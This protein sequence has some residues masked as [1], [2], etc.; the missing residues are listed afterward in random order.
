MVNLQEKEMQNTDSKFGLKPKD[1]RRAKE[2][3]EIQ[4]LH[5]Q[6]TFNSSP[7]QGQI[8]IKTHTKPFLPKFLL[9]IPDNITSDSHKSMLKGKEMEAGSFRYRLLVI[10]S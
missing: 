10:I 9:L 8:N 3:R 1:Y 6:Q 7:T 4:C 5:L 2:T